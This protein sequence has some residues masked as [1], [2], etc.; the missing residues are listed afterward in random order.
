[1]DQQLLF[2]KNIFNETNIQLMNATYTS[3][4]QESQQ[5]FHAINWQTPSLWI[6]VGTV[7]LSPLYWNVVARNEYKN[8]TLT[9]L[10]GTKELACWFFSASV[11]ILG[12]YRDYCFTVAI[13]DQPHGPE[14]FP[15]L[16]LPAVVAFG[17]IIS[18]IGS[19]FVFFS[20]KG[21]GI[22]G[23]YLG[24]YFGIL[25]TERVTGFPFNVVEHP[26]YYGSTM[27][28]LGTAIWYASPVG[29]LLSAWVLIVYLVAGVGFEEEFTNKIY[30]NALKK[31]A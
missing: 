23:T 5:A 12:L 19:M 24:D 15:F 14:A 28:F 20:M 26:M 17:Y 31:T 8:K 6:S 25:K 1:M 2:L 27:C 13:K 18:T 4:I 7:V 21:L 29:V 3:L 22:H 11:F 10:F 30:S 16:S 9:K